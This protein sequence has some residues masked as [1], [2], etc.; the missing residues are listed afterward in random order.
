MDVVLAANVLPVGGK[1]GGNY[2]L[3]RGSFSGGTYSFGIKL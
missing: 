1:L 3:Y 2:D